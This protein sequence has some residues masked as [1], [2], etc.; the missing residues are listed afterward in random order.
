MSKSWQVKPHSD[1]LIYR[2]TKTLL[3]VIERGKET[4]AQQEERI[5]DLQEMLCRFTPS[6]DYQEPDEDGELCDV[7]Y[8]GCFEYDE[9]SE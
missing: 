6:N 5:A 1:D 7:N 4:I 2:H 9:N 3:D 8:D